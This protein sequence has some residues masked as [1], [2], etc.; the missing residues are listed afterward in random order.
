V[1]VSQ[2]AGQFIELPFGYKELTAQYRL[3]L[4]M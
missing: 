4:A 2:F 3:W 1:I